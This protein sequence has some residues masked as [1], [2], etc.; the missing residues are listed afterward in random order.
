MLRTPELRDAL[1]IERVSLKRAKEFCR[2]ELYEPSDLDD[3]AA[4]RK[5]D[6][7]VYLALEMFSERKPYRELPKSLQLDLRAF[8]GS[9]A[10]A[11]IDAR[12]LL[13]SVG[14]TDAV[15][16]A[17][18]EMADEG[19]GYLV[20]EGQLQFHSSV[21]KQFPE[22]LRCYVGCAGILY[23]EMENADLIK[24]HMD[25]GKLTLQ[26]F[27]K[28]LDPL[29]ELRMRVKIDMRSQHVQVFNYGE[30]DRQYLFMKS[31]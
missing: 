27:E 2:N 4:E 15:R 18:D 21:L 29:P 20:N 23:G 3:S 6:L 26:S 22:I 19:L 7:R 10:N 14:D 17:C 1:K 30:S 16:A 12:N 8:W 9:Q 13:F 31:L 5:D 25:T 11:Q 28:N 24:I